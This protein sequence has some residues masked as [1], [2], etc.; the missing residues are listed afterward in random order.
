MRIALLS[1]THGHLCE[2]TLFHIQGSDEIWHAGDVGNVQLLQ[3]LQKIA[4]LRVVYGNIDSADVRQQSQRHLLLYPEWGGYLLIHIAGGLGR[5]NEETRLLIK[6]YQP[7]ALM[8][9]HSHILK[10]AQDKVFNLL[11]VNPGAAGKHGFHKIRTLIKFELHANGPT[12]MQ[13]VELGSR[14]SL[15]QP[16]N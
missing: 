4:P 9:G 13:I 3:T 12:A 10:V 11:Y 6:K 8:C 16:I 2:R 1:D 14:T 5:Y 7:K 15:P